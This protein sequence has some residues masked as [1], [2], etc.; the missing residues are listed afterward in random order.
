MTIY[1]IDEAIRRAYELAVD[2][3]TG[4]VTDEGLFASIDELQLA[5]DAKIDNVACWVKDL[6]GDAEKIKAEAK[7]LTARAKAAENKAERLK[8]Y[9]AY[10]L[11]GEKFK[12]PRS[13]ISYRTSK[14]VE[15]E[16]EALHD[17][18]AEY[19]R[20]KEPEPDKTAIKKALQEGA[21]IPGCRLVENTS[22]IIK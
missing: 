11:Q 8:G 17:L 6:L 2:Q 3:E 15:V 16:E 4:E 7:N 10:A 1:E 5:R 19:L 18:P 21:E 12:S 9:L 22:I 20:Y 14:S 13:A